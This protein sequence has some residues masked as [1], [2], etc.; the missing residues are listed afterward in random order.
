[1]NEHRLKTKIEQNPARRETEKD[2][3]CTDPWSVKVSVRRD[4]GRGGK[5]PSYRHEREN[6]GGMEGVQKLKKP[7][8]AHYETT[9]AP[10]YQPPAPEA[11]AKGLPGS[12][13]T[14]PYE[15]FVLIGKMGMHQA[16]IRR[17]GF[18]HLERESAEHPHTYDCKAQ[19]LKNKFRGISGRGK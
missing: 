4:Q 9:W 2:I 19:D 11:A 5:N 8:V 6:P 12:P 1:V 18:G 14:K 10:G 17:R 3:I 7:P 16:K 13:G 15:S